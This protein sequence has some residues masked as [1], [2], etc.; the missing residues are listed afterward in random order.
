MKY[1]LFATDGPDDHDL[2]VGY[3]KKAFD[4]PDDGIN[5]Y[6][7]IYKSQYND[8]LIASFD[9]EKLIILYRSDQNSSYYK[10]YRD[11]WVYEREE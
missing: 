10:P 8:G 5:Y 7:S 6:N 9:G 11:G 4:N 2:E 3:F 1:L